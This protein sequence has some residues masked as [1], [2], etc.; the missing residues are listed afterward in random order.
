MFFKKPI[1]IGFIGRCLDPSRPIWTHSDRHAQA[2]AAPV[3]TAAR[4]QANPDA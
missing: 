4:G 1:P 3:S 2:Q